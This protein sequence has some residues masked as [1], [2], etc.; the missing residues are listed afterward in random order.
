MKKIKDQNKKKINR[1]KF[2]WKD[3]QIDKA[4]AIL[5]KKKNTLKLLKSGIKEE[6]WLPTGGIKRVIIPWTTVCQWFS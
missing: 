1:I 5:I 4:L 3:Q 6:T 2:L